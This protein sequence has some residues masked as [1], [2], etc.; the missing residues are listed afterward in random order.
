M[1]YLIGTK[2]QR[3][4]FED[5]HCIP[6]FRFE[7]QTDPDVVAM[8]NEDD[9][10]GTLIVNLDGKPTYTVQVCG[11]EGGIDSETEY[12]TYELALEAYER[13]GIA[14]MLRLYKKYDRTQAEED[15]REFDSLEEARAEYDAI[16]LENPH[17]A[18]VKELVE[19]FPDGN[20]GDT[21][22]T[23]ELDRDDLK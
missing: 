17:Y 8:Y 3:K 4:A 20:V 14:Y 6:Y 5:D 10:R 19:V 18:M 23:E 21:I 11:I 15:G 9:G 13:A 2:E 7:E 12:P 16:V 1:L 22:A